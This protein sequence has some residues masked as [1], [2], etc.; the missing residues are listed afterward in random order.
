VATEIVLR[1]VSADKEDVN[2]F[3]AGFQE[4]PWE[5][6]FRSIQYGGSSRSML[7]IESGGTLVGGMALDL[8]T[9]P[10][11]LVFFEVIRRYRNRGKGKTALLALINLLLEMGKRKLFVQTGRP[12]IY[13]RMGFRF[14][15]VERS[16]IVLELER[17]L[18]EREV[19][20]DTPMVLVY[21]D[22]Y[23]WHD[24]YEMPDSPHRV[25]RTLSH[26]KQAGLLERMAVVSPR[27]AKEEEIA[28]VHDIGYI[29]RVRG[30]SE[31]SGRFGKDTQTC[32]ETF[33]IARL[34]FGGA[35][36]AGEYIEDWRR[37]FVLCRPPGHHAR[38]D[39]AAGFCFFNNMG[40]L[41]ISLF[42]KGYRPFVIDWDAHH[43][44]G[45]QEILYDK[46]IPFVSLHQRDL[47][48]WTGTPQERGH[49]PGLGFNYNI[50]LPPLCTDEQYIE[51]FDTVCSMV[52]KHRPD[53]LLVSAG[54]DGHREDRLSGM[55]LSDSCYRH[56]AR[57]ARELADKF[58]E[59]RI[60]LLME[61]GYNLDLLGCLNE[62]VISEVAGIDGKS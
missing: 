8:T 13:R 5:A 27:Y 25:S 4:F 2:P 19:P 38:R 30:V 18:I 47:Y 1:P 14:V 20:P 10:P 23:Q 59:G 60:I 9:T 45:T 37:V 6:Q 54:Q 39:Q 41:A 40:G 33:D 24:A 56:I 32:P 17:P 49:G 28:E 43:G 44:N 48:P 3:G 22:A 29:E 11:Q 12:I 55:M 51:A 16:G 53:V 36:L 61:G 42:N 34:A 58:C 26:L 52:D 15:P 35:L 31:R 7:A 50:P 62:I 21:E 46:P 57:T